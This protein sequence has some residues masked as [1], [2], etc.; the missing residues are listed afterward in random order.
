MKDDSILTITHV[1][2]IDLSGEDMSLI[3]KVV[4]QTI[5]NKYFVVVYRKHDD[6]WGLN[7]NSINVLETFDREAAEREF[8]YRCALYRGEV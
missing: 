1:E 5:F 3:Y 4:I 6:G 2:E 7:V 8:K